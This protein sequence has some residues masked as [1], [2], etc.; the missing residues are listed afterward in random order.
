MTTEA[1]FA[2]VANVVQPHMGAVAVNGNPDYVAATPR[3]KASRWMRALAAALNRTQAKA[4]FAPILTEAAQ[5][6]R[7][8]A[9]PALGTPRPPGAPPPDSWALQLT[10]GSVWTTGGSSYQ[11]IA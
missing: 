7:M 3:E 4:R 11:F 9:M 2:V 10:P 8:L 5:V 1:M 6:E